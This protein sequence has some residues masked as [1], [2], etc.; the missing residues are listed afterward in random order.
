[1]PPIDSPHQCTLDVEVVED[2]QH[3]AAEALHGIGA[4]RHAGFAV[5]ALVIADHA[6]KLREYVHLRFPHF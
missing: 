6:E 2:R 3:V 4:G 1:M 5:A